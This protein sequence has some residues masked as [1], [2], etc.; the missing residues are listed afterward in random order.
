MANNRLTELLATAED[1]LAD[2]KKRRADLL[3][4]L[5]RQIENLEAG[6]KAIRLAI[7][8]SPVVTK[9]QAPTSNGDSTL[10]GP[11]PAQVTLDFIKKHPGLVSTQVIERLHT[12][13]PARGSKSSRK[14]ISG[15]VYDLRLRKK[16]VVNE[17]G[18]MYPV[19]EG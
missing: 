4:P 8:P 19:K 9:H 11:T 5:D 16:I 1:H 10:A 18:R 6:V 2:L 17:D 3:G 15:A 14:V 12:Q 7:E 13:V